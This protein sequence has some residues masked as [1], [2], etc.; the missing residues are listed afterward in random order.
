MIILSIVIPCYNE[1]KSINF[2]LDKFDKI[3]EKNNFELILV[4]NG[5]SDNTWKLLKEKLEKYKFLKV[6]KIKH[7]IGYGHGIVSGLS[8]AKGKFVGWTHADLQTDIFD[9]NKAY[10]I[11]KEDGLRKDLYIKGLRKNRNLL[12]QIFTFGMTI[13]ESILLRTILI[14]INAQPNIFPK[15]FIEKW[16]KPPDD[17]LLDLY[18]YVLAKKS[19]YRVKRFDVKFEKRK[20]GISSWNINWKS[21]FIFTFKIFIGSIILKSKI[22]SLSKISLY[23]N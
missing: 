23:N 10:K 3:P 2:I 9:I 6:L 13:F 4:D 21:K 17:F 8:I 14:D 16:E 22:N 5:S 19:S 11:L 18:S 7:N 20:F 12:D 1:E 15:E